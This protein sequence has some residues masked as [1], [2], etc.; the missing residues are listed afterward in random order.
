MR[1]IIKTL[2][3]KK[4][5]LSK[6]IKYLNKKKQLK[7]LETQIKDSKI[8][9][10]NLKEEFDTSDTG[11]KRDNAKTRIERI[12]KIIEDKLTAKAR[13]KKEIQ[14]IESS[15][16]K[17]LD[18]ETEKY[19]CIP[20]DKNV[21]NVDYENE[22]NIIMRQELHP[23]DLGING[24]IFK[25]DIPKKAETFFK[26]DNSI[27]LESL[28]GGG[29]QTG[30][31]P[32][33]ITLKPGI[34]KNTIFDKEFSELED[35]NE[36]VQNSKN[37]PQKLK[38][39]LDNLI[40]DV[41]TNEKIDENLKT[42][43]LGVLNI[44]TLEGA[45]PFK[46][47]N[48]SYDEI[49]K[50]LNHNKPEGAYLEIS[51]PV[52][53]PEPKPGPEPEPE[54]VNPV[55]PEKNK[56]NKSY[57]DDFQEWYGNYVK[58]IEAYV[59]TVNKNKV[60]K[61]PKV[62]NVKD[63]DKYKTVDTIISNVN[64]DIQQL[65][66]QN[67]LVE[68]YI[69]YINYKPD[70][71]KNDKNNIEALKEHLTKFGENLPN[72]LLVEFVN[73]CKTE[74]TYKNLFIKDLTLEKGGKN[75]ANKMN[76]NK[77]K[78]Y[79]NLDKIIEEINNKI[80]DYC[81]QN[82]FEIIEPFNEQLN[83]T[84]LR[85][86]I[87][88]IKTYLQGLKFEKKQSKDK[89]SPKISPEPESEPELIL[90]KP[91]SNSNSETEQKC[92]LTE[93][94]VEEFYNDIHVTEVNGLLNQTRIKLT[95]LNVSPIVGE[96]KEQRQIECTLPAIIKQIN[97][98]HT[99]LV[100]E[101]NNLNINLIYEE[102]NE[103]IDE[104]IDEEETKDN[105]KALLNKF[106][107]KLKEA[108]EKAKQKPI[109][110]NFYIIKFFNDELRETYSNYFEN[111]ENNDLKNLM[112]ELI[113]LKK[114]NVSNED[115]DSDADQYEKI[116]D[117]NK[118]F[119]VH[120]ILLKQKD[121]DVF[122]NIDDFITTI[123][124]TNNLII[125]YNNI[126]IQYNDEFEYLKDFINTEKIDLTKEY[127]SSL[128]HNILKHN[129]NTEYK[130]KLALKY[131]NNIEI[132]L[133][134]KE[135]DNF[136]NFTKNF[137][138]E[139][140]KTKYD[141][142]FTKVQDKK[143][144]LNKKLDDNAKQID[145]KLATIQEQIKEA[146]TQKESLENER[147]EV[148]KKL[149]EDKTE[150]E[151]LSNKIAPLKKTQTELENEKQAIKDVLSKQTQFY[152]LPKYL[153]GQKDAIKKKILDNVDDDDEY[154]NKKN[155][156]D[157]VDEIINN[158][159]NTLL[160]TFKNGLKQI[161][162]LSDT[163]NTFNSTSDE[164]LTQRLEEAQQNSGADIEQIQELSVVEIKTLFINDIDERIDDLNK[165]IFETFI[166]NFKKKQ[167][168]LEKAEYVRE[169]VYKFENIIRLMDQYILVA[170][171]KEDYDEKADNLWIQFYF[172]YD[173]FTE[174]IQNLRNQLLTITSKYN[175]N[176][177]QITETENKINQLQQQQIPKDEK[178]VKEISD[179]LNT[180]N[181]DNLDKILKEGN[182]L[183]GEISRK[184]AKL[185][186]LPLSKVTDKNIVKRNFEA[187]ETI[188]K[189][190]EDIKK[191]ITAIEAKIKKFP[192][193]SGK[194]AG[195]GKYKKT[196]KAH[197]HLKTRINKNSKKRSNKK[198]RQVNL[199]S[200][201]KLVT[202]RYVNKSQ[203][204][205]SKKLNKLSSHAKVKIPNKL[206]QTLSKLG[207]TASWNYAKRGGA[208]KLKKRY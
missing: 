110:K 197:R 163:I 24:P 142:L 88:N 58:K 10:E 154:I 172:N 205:K 148:Q 189:K 147:A 29:S 90:G 41:K 36:R 116:K 157:I 170:K 72:Y 93:D 184:N 30:G 11:K 23:Y 138:Q 85:K 152:R 103:K 153:K 64:S 162:E 34:Q 144:E 192:N 204:T 31:K 99:K 52:E 62:I 112:K 48:P 3:L 13:L 2:E 150:A 171:T 186:E 188:E 183:P 16:P 202:S 25:L 167:T 76:P 7:K 173:N 96:P 127:K 27:E 84:D 20:G 122:K 17:S 131:T 135:N 151:D 45:N 194:Q 191:E 117:H 6:D 155:F 108:I 208:R 39:N 187:L 190:L 159:N 46:S 203:K 176:K 139:K 89:N 54:P 86:R 141:E 59:Y 83:T 128:L 149:N 174:Q 9:L 156:E 35:F 206:K 87:E 14:E 79:K 57:L 60:N 1:R 50:Y 134:T 136:F 66:T 113:N 119:P 69:S 180:I 71:S 82:K 97:D 111:N 49:L 51:L 37:I 125:D 177:K 133:N 120:K 199:L 193:K 182:E 21:K 53:E 44:K 109:E 124:N 68:K 140:L 126:I 178:K 15:V 185:N 80:S 105:I 65:I 146:K 81:Q 175:N 61:L 114:I 63:G 195:G 78:E 181:T 74:C 207:H 143:I 121:K 94:L 179:K 18:D 26:T 5:D 91:V 38:D 164:K 100:E 137:I 19:S 73:W 28:T 130:T 169:T 101:L 102:I 165:D 201:K 115:N 42:H 8:L 132:L 33:K 200:L 22:C 67:D 166:T 70:I 55:E 198:S 145:T 75:L 168:L 196:R 12:Q 118:E 123:E 4:E 56:E 43:V 95:D 77:P 160:K 129:K 32:F 106:V 107:V 47:I 40:N 161:N 92:N 158:P 98:H 104:K